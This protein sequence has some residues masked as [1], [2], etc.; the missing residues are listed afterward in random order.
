M[1][2]NPEKLVRSLT[3]NGFKYLTEEFGS[4]NLELLK[5]NG[6]YPY[7]YMDSFKRFN[8]KELPDKEFFYRSVKDGT[9]D[10]DGKKLDR[11]I[12]DEEYLMGQKIWDT[13]NMKDMRHYHDHYLKKDY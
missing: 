12:T 4:K 11:R 8:E 13:F 5:Q 9:T 2:F 3:D 10:N 7:G 1:N 6:A